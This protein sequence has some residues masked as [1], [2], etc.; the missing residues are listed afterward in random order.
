MIHRVAP[1]TP[2]LASHFNALADAINS[3]TPARGGAGISVTQTAGR[4]MVVALDAPHL[5]YILR[6]RI[7]AASATVPTRAADLNYSVAAIGSSTAT[8]AGAVPI[9][10]VFS[11][12]L[13]LLQPAAVGDPCYIL[14]FPDD[15]PYLFA[16]TER[17]HV[18][19]CD[20][21]PL[22]SA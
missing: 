1:G 4:G 10:R 6:A 16:L 12:G 11:S 15:E 22:A 20:S 21:P 2:V 19:V 14:R 5:D 3:L 7:T 18:A 13:V 9:N 17:V 8:M